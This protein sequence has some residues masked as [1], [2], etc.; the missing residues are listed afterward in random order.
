MRLTIALLLGFAASLHAQ[1][2]FSDTPVTAAPAAVTVEKPVRRAE[3][4][5]P[6]AA[7]VAKAVPVAAPAAGEGR[8][9]VVLRAGD[10]FQLRL[11]GMP[12]ED[13]AAFPPE[14]TIGQDGMI[15]ITYA[16]QIR[17]A[18]LTQSQ[19]ERTIENRLVS[20]KIFRDPTANVIVQAGA[21]YVTIGG[22]VRG[23]G[24]QPWSSDL[25]LLS[26]ISAAGGPSDFAGRRVNLIRGGQVT[27][28]DIRKLNKNPSED[29]K[30]FPGDRIDYL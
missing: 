14:Y 26:A 1:T 2:S 29:P 7:S 9:N 21:R 4:V 6:R 10:S 28:F 12:A 15:N 17:A 18:G 25:T 24:R 30:L 20:E 22:N 5:A 27:T 23:P 19:L 8:G 13:A 16:G 11:S 3:P